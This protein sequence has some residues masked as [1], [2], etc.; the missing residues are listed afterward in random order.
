MVMMQVKIC[1][2]FLPKGTVEKFLP[3]NKHLRI[4]NEETSQLETEMDAD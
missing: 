4:L 1:A 2:K 3:A